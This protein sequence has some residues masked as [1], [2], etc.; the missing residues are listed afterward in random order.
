MRRLR[1][2]LVSLVVS[3]LSSSAQ[4]Q[5]TPTPAAPAPVPAAPAAPVVPAAAGPTASAEGAA[6][7]AGS[8]PSLQEVLALVNRHFPLLAAAERDRAVAQGDLMAAQGGFDPLWRTRAAWIPVGYY[9]TRRLDTV[10]TQPTSLWGTSFFAGYRFGQGSFAVYDGKAATLTGG[11]VRAGVAVPLLRDGPIDARRA[12]LGSAQLGPRLAEQGVEAQRIEVTRAVGLRYWTW[13][14]SGK[15]L[16]IAQQM[17][18]LAEERDE[19]LAERVQRG[20]LA[21]IERD[22]NLRSIL[23]RRSAVVQFERALQGARFELEYYLRGLPGSAILPAG[24][25]VPDFPEPTPP[26]A[27]NL[28]EEAAAAA[29]RRPDVARLLTQREQLR[30]ERQMAE[31]QA[32]PALDFQATASKDVGLGAGS[33]R[34]FDVELALTLDVPLLARVARGKAESAAAKQ[35][36]IDFQ[37]AALRNRILADLRDAAVAETAAR[38]RLDLARRELALARRLAAAERE[39]FKLGQSTALLVNL[40]EQAVGD[41]ALREL[42]ALADFQ[43]ALVVY[44]AVAAGP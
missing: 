31:N 30:F 42:T 8:G 41:A 22:E 12:A 36:K 10:L 27:R 23:S 18:R 34:P 19:A 5:T 25:R 13:V 17:L 1:C 6:P 33:L 38:E 2:L 37:V 3:A 20:D 14:E 4:A 39:A 11:E 43:R 29:A 21:S 35:A 9:Q 44:R 7:A 15:A 24:N 40:R 28:D 32:R 26:T 16:Q